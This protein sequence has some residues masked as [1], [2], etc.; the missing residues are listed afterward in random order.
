M[1]MNPTY[2]LTTAVDSLDLR[3]VD[4][5][6]VP[7]PPRVLR[8]RAVNA[9]Q[10]STRHLSVVGRICARFCDLREGR[11]QYSV[12]TL[13]QFGFYLFLFKLSIHMTRM[14]ENVER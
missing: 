3:V 12:L 13:N 4:P 8:I 9:I 5:F 7:Y 11:V 6:A 1:K 10:H 14:L 2:K